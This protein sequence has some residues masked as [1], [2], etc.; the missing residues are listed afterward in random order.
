MGDMGKAI[1]EITR[2]SEQTGKIIKTIDEIAFQTNLLA[3]NAA[4]E[5]ARAGEAGAGFAVVADEVRNLAL[6]ASEAAKSTT[7]LIEQTVKAVKNGNQL[8]ASTQS[9]FAENR[10]VTL[11]VSGIVDEIA[12]ASSE[13][14]QGI[15]QINKAVSEIEKI[16]QQNASSAEECASASEEMTSQAGL[17]KGFVRELAAIVEGEDRRDMRGSVSDAGRSAEPYDRQL[18]MDSRGE[19][20][21]GR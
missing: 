2:S 12:A 14:A 10:N 21:P 9:A 5:A 16:V 17:M 15:D 19:D 3:L 13:Q 11:K 18:P 8:T 20:G 6:R 4:V 1:D 7:L